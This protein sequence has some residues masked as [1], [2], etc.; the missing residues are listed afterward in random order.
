MTT[1]QAAQLLGVSR[2]HVVDL[3]SRN[4][5]PSVRVG[6]HRRIPRSAVQQLAGHR[7]LRREEE[8]SRWLHLAVVGVLVRDPGSVLS[9][10]RRNLDAWQGIH[11]ED[12]RAAGYLREWEQLL[13]A[14][15]D[16][17]IEMLLSTSERACDLRQNSP[18]A[19]VLTEAHRQQILRSF[20]DHWNRQ[21]ALAG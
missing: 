9:T 5:L 4:A 18:F 3:C 15:L 12:G 20:T 11:R 2:Q 16:D 21:H 7:A 17:V 19:G 13:D 8:K 10:A 1:G 6:T 14:G